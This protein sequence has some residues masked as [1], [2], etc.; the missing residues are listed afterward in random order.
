MDSS[1]NWPAA[2]RRRQKVDDQQTA[3]R[4]SGARFSSNSSSRLH[5]AP[6]WPPAIDTEAMA[7]PV[8]P[9][10]PSLDD[11]RRRV[12]SPA[13]T[14]EDR[15]RYR[16]ALDAAGGDRRM[17]PEPVAT[18]QPDAEGSAAADGAPQATDPRRPRR[19]SQSFL[20]AGAVAALLVAAALAAVLPRTIDGPPPP[21]PT[22]IAVDAATRGE[23]LRN[24]TDS[25]AAGIAAYIVTH[26]APP[27]SATRYFTIER[28]GTG[29]RTLALHPT[30]TAT[31]R[32]RA[33]VYLVLDRFEHAAW[34]VSAVRPT[35]DS[36]D[37]LVAIATQAGLQ[38]GGV[39]TVAT[40][41]YAPGHPP[42]RLRIDVPKGVRWG[43]AVIFTD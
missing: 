38:E 1:L 12:Y 7:L 13:A 25:G 35:T 41:A 39:P 16:A 22:P 3:A 11:L 23:F 34:T 6:G 29:P 2:E 18:A 9:V 33:T 4:T 40:F 32:G 42:V 20:L 14:A 24:L 19:R 8:D 43:A 31:N 36:E 28:W 17:Q 27:R 5:R 30:D 21:A 15:A 10:G 26:P 37:P